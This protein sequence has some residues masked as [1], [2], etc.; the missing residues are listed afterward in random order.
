M[1]TLATLTLAL[2]AAACGPTAIDEGALLSAADARW[3]DA[4]S[5]HAPLT[6]DVRALM[7]R[8]LTAESAAQIALANNRGVRAVIEELGIVE[9]RATQAR[10]L[11][12]P[13]LEGAMRFEGDGRPELEVGAMIDVTD[14]L[15]LATR[16]S[17]AGAE[18]EAAKMSAVGALLDLAYDTRRAFYVHQAAA[19][20]AELRRTV[21]QAFTA[22]A[23]LARRLR[24]A[25]N[26]TEL[27]LANERS[28]FEEA[29]LEL[30]AA[31]LGVATARE[32]LN[33]LMGLWGRGTEWRTAARL[34]EIPEREL[35]LEKLEAAAVKRSL[36]LAIAKQRFAGAAKRANAA[37][38]QGW[39]PELK[40]GVSAERSDE[41][42]VGPAVEIEVPLFYQGQ[43]EAGVA[44]SEM[45]Q[46]QNLYT[47]FAVT[48]RANA[49][50]AGTRLAAKREALLYYKSVLLPLK[51]QVVDQSQLEYNAM[52]IGLFQLLQAK[53][54]QVQTAA[55]YIEHQRDYWIAR[56][57]VEQ[58]LAGRQPPEQASGD[59]RSTTPTPGAA[60]GAH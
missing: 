4:G 43:G 34:P 7:A 27:D 51:Q 18:V 52:L 44:E 8:P 30:Q 41:W 14:L 31:E 55:A 17:A 48:L 33:A 12:N 37:Q 32:R 21:L 20:L 25:G 53:R 58:L 45:R 1:R 29:R 46:Q 3:R 11:P 26:I 23:D 57:N 42:A 19:E 47:E 50:N 60:E 59:A 35:A 36:D 6:K 56:T 2:F 13:T 38:A 39:L 54:D 49:R 22:S 5:S 28:L 15:L 16:S 24:D 10:R 40:A 9:A